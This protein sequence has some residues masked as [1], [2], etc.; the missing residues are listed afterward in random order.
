MNTAVLQ[1]RWRMV[2]I[3]AAAALVLLYSLGPFL[4]IFIASV[5]PESTAKWGAISGRAVTYL[6]TRPTFQNYID[7][8]SNTPFLQ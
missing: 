4:W 3:Y 7:L 1:R 8:L 5:T 2:G 6:P